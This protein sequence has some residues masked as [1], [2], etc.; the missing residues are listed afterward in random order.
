LAQRG[1]HAPRHEKQSNEFN[2]AFNAE[3]V[4]HNSAI[5]TTSIIPGAPSGANP[6]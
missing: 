5:G 2:G 3:K 1:H 4:L 6:E